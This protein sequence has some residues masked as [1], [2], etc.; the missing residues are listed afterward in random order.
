[1]RHRDSVVFV[2][3]DFCAGLDEMEFLVVCDVLKEPEEVVNDLNAAQVTVQHVAAGKKTNSADERLRLAMRKFVDTHGGGGSGEV[4]LVL[5]SGDQDFLSDLSYYRRSRGVRVVLLHN[6]VAGDNLK[7]AANVAR[8]FHQMLSDL[9]SSRKA[10]GAGAPVQYT[11][12]VVGNLPTL[13][14]TPH[15]SNV[16]RKLEEMTKSWYVCWCAFAH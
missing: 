3:Q 15:G 7:R 2:L 9:P 10:A 8:D 5:I 14:E 16:E 6:Q 12:L 4:V 13:Q 1:M 11:E